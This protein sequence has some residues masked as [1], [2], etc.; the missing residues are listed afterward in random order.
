MI[1]SY[2]VARK[3]CRS[4]L[5]RNTIERVKHFLLKAYGNSTITDGE[6]VFHECLKVCQWGYF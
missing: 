2:V 4:C 1:G 3:S 6:K 5:L